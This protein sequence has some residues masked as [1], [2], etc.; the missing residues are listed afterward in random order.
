[1]R[2]CAFDR[3]DQS[4]DVAARVEEEFLRQGENFLSFVVVLI[5]CQALKKCCNG[6]GERLAECMA[7]LVRSKKAAHFRIFC[8]ER[9]RSIESALIHPTGQQ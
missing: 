3:F 1:M 2:L 4:A 8:D 9:D 5:P 7:Y 6:L